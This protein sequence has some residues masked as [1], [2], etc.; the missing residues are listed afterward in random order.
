[1]EPTWMR[2]IYIRVCVFDTCGFHN[3]LFFIAQRC[4]IISEPAT[5]EKSGLRNIDYIALSVTKVAMSNSIS[6]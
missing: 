3:P 4:E 6:G 2:A 5:N 1:M